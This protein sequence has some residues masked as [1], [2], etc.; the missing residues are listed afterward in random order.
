[1]L[2]RL[3]LLALCLITACE[4]FRGSARRPRSE[5]TPEEFIEV[6]VALANARTPVERERVLEQH[7]T[8]EKAL[9]EFV[10]AYSHDVTRLSATFDSA[11]ARLSAPRL[12]ESSRPQ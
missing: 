7:K 1:M 12:E 4:V 9:H 8:S 2:M 5:L 11:V 6:Y 10:Q 3:L